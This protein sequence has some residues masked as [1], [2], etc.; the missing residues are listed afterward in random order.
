MPPPAPRH[1]VGYYVH[2]Y[3]LIPA[4][5]RLRGRRTCAYLRG[6]ERSQWLGRSELEALQLEALQRLLRHA[7]RH[8]GYYCDEWARRGLDPRSV[9]CLDD[10]ARWPITD[11]ETVRAYRRAMR[12]DVPGT[13]LVE[14]TTSGSTGSV[15]HFDLDR[16][17][18]ARRLAAMHRGYG[19]AGGGLGSRHLRFWA[20]DVGVSLARS[21]RNALYGWIYRRCAEANPYDV[22]ELDPSA[23]VRQF[24]ACDADVIVAFVSPIHAAAQVLEQAGLH[25]RRPRGIIVGGEK[26][27]D[28]QREVIE[29]VF[30]AR[31]FET[32][33]GR[34]SL[35]IGAECEHRSGFHLTMEHLI[36]EV[37]DDEGRPTPPGQEGNVVFT[38]LYSYGAP[39]VRYAN[40]DRAEAGFGSC[41]CGRGL[42]LL[43][44][45]VGRRLDLI[46]TPD[47]RRIAGALFVHFVKEFA[48]VRRFQVV[49]ERADTVELRLALD[50]QLAFAERHRL[51]GG[52][53]AVLGSSINLRLVEVDDLPLTPSG[54]F[55]VVVNQCLAEQERRGRA[56]AAGATGRPGAPP[57]GPLDASTNRRS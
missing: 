2:R 7:A 36:V 1:T 39:F 48:A 20:P 4:Y 49:Q 47:G 42:P 18:L 26:L 37:L 23:L 5:E 35:L 6:L 14:W 11:R 41:P 17:G 30:G 44:Q 32:Y 50:R 53:R 40:G 38:D 43:R 34:E 8:C 13:R 19:W 31:V 55:R 33:G 46:V 57:D 16:G 21:A 27:H 3:G 22:R 54:K 24:G 29:R 56:A 12:S 10:L 28:A 45:V 25:P 51:E 15:L 52:L 9:H